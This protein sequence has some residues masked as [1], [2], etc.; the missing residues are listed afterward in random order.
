MVLGFLYKLIVGTSLGSRKEQFSSVGVIKV[1]FFLINSVGEKG[2]FFH[3]GCV[4]RVVAVLLRGKDS[5]VS[6]GSSSSANSRPPPHPE[7]RLECSF[8]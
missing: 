8:A 5:I 1:D 4:F 7:F 2:S 3:V 6:T